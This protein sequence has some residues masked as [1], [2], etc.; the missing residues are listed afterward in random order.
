MIPGSLCP[1]SARIPDGG[2]PVRATQSAR[3]AA[4]RV[5]ASSDLTTPSLAH[6]RRRLCHGPPLTVTQSVMPRADARLPPQLSLCR[7]PPHGTAC[8]STRA[9]P[10]PTPPSLPA[11][12]S[13]AL[14]PASPA[15]SQTRARWTLTH[16]RWSLEFSDSRAAGPPTVAESVSTVIHVP[17]AAP[18]PP[19]LDQSVQS[20]EIRGLGSP[21]SLEVRGQHASPSAEVRGPL[22][23][24]DPSPAVDS[25]GRPL[26]T[27]VETSL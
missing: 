16:C 6:R 19:L 14:R 18:P 24:G 20:A 9:T 11:I 26:S 3:H 27:T 12:G 2:P 21:T 4:T 23:P 25:P 8:P 5:P 10:R 22:P 7:R 13:P 17:A 1:P 15:Q